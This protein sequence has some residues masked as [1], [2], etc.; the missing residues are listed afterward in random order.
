MVESAAVYNLSGRPLS[1]PCMV[2]RCTRCY[3]SHSALASTCRELEAAAASAAAA[4]AA[5]AGSLS[6]R[7]RLCAAER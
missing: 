4:A 6:N 7:S 3:G 2:T 1:Q 5:D